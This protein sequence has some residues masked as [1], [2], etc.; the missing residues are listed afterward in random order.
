MITPDGADMER[1]TP[2]ALALLAM[3]ASSAG[4][5]ASG[6]PAYADER[7]WAASGDGAAAIA[8][9]AAIAETTSVFCWLAS[10]RPPSS[11]S[12]CRGP[13]RRQAKKTPS[14]RS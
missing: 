2:N 1:V 4:W 8:T 9:D 12:T 11:K 10:N 5:L 3:F 13:R 7:I 6:A 14:R